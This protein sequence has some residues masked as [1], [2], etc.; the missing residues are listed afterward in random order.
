MHRG[1]QFRK[2]GNQFEKGEINLKKGG[3]LSGSMRKVLS[4]KH[5]NNA[6]LIDEALSEAF[7]QLFVNAYLSPNNAEIIQRIKDLREPKDIEECLFSNSN[8]SDLKRTYNDVKQKGLLA[9]DNGKTQQYWLKYNELIDRQQQ[10]NFAINTNDFSLKLH[11][12]D[13]LL[14]F[15]T[16]KAHCK[17]WE[18]LFTSTPE[19]RVNPS[20]SNG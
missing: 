11:S 18:L 12:W 8:V 10:F 13:L 6:W 14:C 15:A 4:E 2:R 17:I 16:N 5:C 20:W 7:E 9:G 3:H 1:K 19:P